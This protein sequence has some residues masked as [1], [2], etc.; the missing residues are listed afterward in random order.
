[1]AL[2]CRESGSLSS[3]YPYFHNEWYQN[4]VQ[5]GGPGPKDHPATS[6]KVLYNYQ[7]IVNPFKQVGFYVDLLEYCDEKGQFHFKEWDE[8]EGFVYRSKRFDHR[9]QEGKLGFVSLIIDVT[10]KRDRKVY[11]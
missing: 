4:I 11:C 2:F 9:N 8:K 5:V 7:N 3:K 6:H 1:M 10:K